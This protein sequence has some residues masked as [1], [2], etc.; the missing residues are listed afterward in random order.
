MSSHS[1]IGG[2]TAPPDKIIVASGPTVLAG[3]PI[4]VDSVNKL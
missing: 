4:G 1:Y 2:A 3:A